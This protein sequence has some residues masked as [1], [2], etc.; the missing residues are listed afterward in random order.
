MYISQLRQ[1]N[2]HNKNVLADALFTL[3]VSCPR[4]WRRRL[5]QPR[6]TFAEDAPP[7]HLMASCANTTVEILGVL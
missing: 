5:W 3:L 4:L 6:E 2:N 7:L 1:Q